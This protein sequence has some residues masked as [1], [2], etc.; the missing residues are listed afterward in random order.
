MY[1]PVCGNVAGVV[2][3]LGN[4]A[5]CQCRDCGLWFINDGGDVDFDPSELFE[6]DK[7]F[8]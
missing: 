6:D 3:M 2:G 8:D 4:T 1:C 5:W 7:S